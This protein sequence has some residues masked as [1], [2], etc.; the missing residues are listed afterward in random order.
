MGKQ[1]SVKVRHAKNDEVDAVV[2]FIRNHYYI[3][4]HVYVR[5]RELFLEHHFVN[6][7]L[8]FSLAINE[9]DGSIAGIAGYF[10]SNSSNHPDLFVSML[11]TAGSGSGLTGIKMIQEV[12]RYTGARSL[13]SSGC[14]KSVLPIY[15]F[16]GYEVGSL[17]HYYRYADLPSYSIAVIDNPLEQAYASGNANIVLLETMEEVNSVFDFDSYA[18]NVPYKDADYV[19]RR[20]Y[21][22]LGYDYSV[23]GIMRND[24]CHALMI[25]R[26]VEHAGAKAFKIIDYIGDRYIIGEAGKGI[27]A[28]LYD[29]H[30][31]FIDFYEWGIDDEVMKNAG[32]TELVENDINIIPHYYEPFEQRNIEIFFFA[33]VPENCIVVRA[34]GGQDRPNYLAHEIG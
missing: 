24:V 23:F 34:D 27:D 20:Y 18:D 30:Y 1:N 9:E 19:S 16:L 14:V 2:D 28:L 15:R 21:D 7:S 26:E 22:N 13:I 11:Q 3:H 5:E 33:S 31:E 10:P 25:G 4:N 17:K 8:C 29:R 6:D 32:F 12:E